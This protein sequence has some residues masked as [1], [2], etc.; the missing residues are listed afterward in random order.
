MRVLLHLTLTVTDNIMA[1]LLQS[2]SSF[3]ILQ[4]CLASVF[5]KLFS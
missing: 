2:V 5:F 1:S 3:W 4:A